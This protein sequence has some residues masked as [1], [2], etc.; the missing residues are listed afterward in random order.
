MAARWRI[1]Y[2]GFRRG[3]RWRR[4]TYLVVAVALA[5]LGLVAFV[6]T[7]FATIGVVELAAPGARRSGASGAALAA[8]AGG[9]THV[10]VATTLS[11]VLMLSLLVSFTVAL[12]ALYLSMDLDLLLAAPVDRRAVFASKLLGGLLPSFSMV[13]L[14][15]VVPLLAH[16]LA[17]GYD[18]TY[19]LA[20]GLALLLLP[21][22][23]MALGALAVMLIVRHVSARRLGDVVAL[24]V[25]AMTLSIAFVAGSA[26]QLQEVVSLRD[27]LAVFEGLRTPYSPSEWLTRAV[28]AAAV[29]DLS[30]TL[31]WFGLVG[32]LSLGA[33][34]VIVTVAD[35]LYYQGWEHL[36][37]ADRRRQLS[38][39]HMPWNRVDRAATLGR[40]SGVF[41][42]LSPP[43]VALIRKDFRA[44]P[45]DLTNMAQVLSPLS[46]GVFFVLQRL[47]YPVRLAGFERVQ[48][49]LDPL[50][51]MLSAGIAVGVSAMIM[52]RFSLTAFSGEGRSWW[53]LQSAPISRR[54]VV[55]G[56]FLVAYVPYLLLGMAL[57]VL[58]EA[59]RAVSDV[60]AAGALTVP[61]LV[62]AFDA[63]L[64]LYAWFV[65]AVVGAGVLAINLA[66]GAA[67][68]NMRWDT[69]QEMLTPDVGCLSLVMYGGYGF[70]ASMAL[71][72]PA[73]TSGF[74]SIGQ[75]GPLWVLGFVLGVG[76]T[77]LVV[78]SALA[79]SVREV[80][81]IGEDA[82]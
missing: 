61:A 76:L 1:A 50:L 30:G 54:E 49:Y 47:L 72:T 7:Y 71:L 29:H 16:G 63:W 21:F 33:V 38:E 25:V 36:Q 75:G 35:R 79:L 19:F 22:L 12:A 74:P 45:R 42:R 66:L 11:G 44:I 51:A 23:P 64:I 20:V 15:A 24:V 82:V 46:I 70:V 68:P 10:I 40:P 41:A 5:F 55:V 18:R 58:L 2:N 3:A 17:M 32:A 77:V 14:M 6:G 62:G 26:R 13:T 8:L 81:L 65:V 73:A 53:M 43:T 9:Q 60:H 69:P 4:V 37:S 67:R 48:G 59:A 31:R 57:V 34:A 27:L 52:S 56:K 78:A 80:G 28:S 39:S